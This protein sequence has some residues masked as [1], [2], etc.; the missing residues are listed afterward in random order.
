M[1]RMLEKVTQDQLAEF[2]RLE[3]ERKELESKARAI[4]K[5]TKTLHDHFLA[6]LEGAGRTSVLRSGYRLTI[7]E[8]RASVSWKDAFIE[9]A[10]PLAADELQQKAPRSKKVDVQKA[11]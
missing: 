7:T 5:R 1:A 4:G 9:F 11:A 8:G 6:C 2:V 10:G 3:K